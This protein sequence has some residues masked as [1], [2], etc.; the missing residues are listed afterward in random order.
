MKDRIL[1]LIYIDCVRCIRH[2]RKLIYLFVVFSILSFML[3]ESEI[4][5]LLIRTGTKQVL[6]YNYY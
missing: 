5:A 1:T 4:L 3:L 6:G 2:L